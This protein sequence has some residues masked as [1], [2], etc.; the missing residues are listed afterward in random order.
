MGRSRTAPFPSVVRVVWCVAF[1]L[2]CLPAVAA[3]SSAARPI[4]HASIPVRFEP[5]RGQAPKSVR[6]VGRG[7][8]YRVAL[9]AKQV[10]ISVSPSIPKTVGR[11]ADTA[12]TMALVG[13]NDNASISA[14]GELPGKSSYFLQSDP[15]TWLTNLPTYSSV[16]SRNVYPR[17]DLV[18]RGDG[19]RL[20][21]DFRIGAGGDPARIA[22]RLDAKT[23]VSVDDGDLLVRRG[24]A[25]LRFLKPVSYQEKNGR[26]ETVAS[27][28]RVRH[29]AQG[30]TVEFE[31]G[32]YDRSRALIIDP[33]VL[34]GAVLAYSTQV[35]ALSEIGA[36]TVDGAGDVYLA[37]GESGGIDIVKLAPDGRTLLYD[38][39]I[40]SVYSSATGIAVD[41]QGQIYLTGYTYPGY[42]TTAGAYQ[43][44][45]GSGQHAFL[46]VV[47]ASGTGLIYSTYLEGSSTDYGDSV[48]IDPS[49]YVLVA[50]YTYSPDFPNTTSAQLSGA[51]AAFVTKFDIGQSGAA[52]LLWSTLL[53][54]TNYY[55]SQ[56][57]SV[58][59]DSAGNV[60]L[61]VDA[62]HLATS[63]G[64]YRYNAIDSSSSGVYVVELNSSG[65]Q[66]FVSYLGHGTAFDMA[67]D[68]AGNA[69]V[70]GTV[71]SGDYPATTGA[72]Q[73]SY[74]NAFVTKLNAGGGSLAYSTY[75]GGPSGQITPTSVTLPAGCT[76]NC[77]PL[78][79]GFVYG[80]DMPVV[81]AVQQALWGGTSY[82]NP[83]VFLTYLSADGSGAMFSTYFGGSN[84]DAYFR[85]NN[86]RIPQVGL[87]TAGNMYVAGY[88]YSSDFPFTTVFGSARSFVAKISP[89]AG[90]LVLPD[91]RSLSFGGQTM[92]VS[93]ASQTVNLRNFGT[94]AATIF[95]GPS[96]DNAGFTTTDNC[97]GTIP[98]GGS[99]AVQVTFTPKVAGYVSG[100]IT[101]GYNGNFATSFNVNGTGYDQPQ[102]SISPTTGA[103]F[104][105]V[106]VGTASTPQ[107]FTLT[108]IGS[109]P[110]S[111]N[112]VA[113]GDNTNF[114]LTATNCPGVL[115]V[116]ASCSFSIAFTPTRVGS[117]TSNFY[118]SSNA[119][120]TPSYS[121]YLT[122]TGTG[123]GTAAI[124]PSSTALNF[125]DQVVN[126]QS[127]AQ[128]VTFTNTGTIPVSL[129][130]GSTT[131][132]FSITSA[133][134]N[135]YTL[136]PGDSCT[137]YVAFTPATSGTRTGT[138]TMPNSTGTN[139]TVSLTGTGTAPTLGLTIS[140][141][142]LGF[143]DQ[144]VGTTSGANY[145]SVTN[146]GNATV[147]VS[148]V[149]DSG[150]DFHIT[151]NGCSTI[152]PLSSCQVNA[153]FTPSAA[154]ARTGTITFI[155]T[156]G[157]SPQVVSLSGNGMASTSS[158]I[159]SETSSTFDD[160]VVGSAGP[161]NALYLFNPGNT[162]VSVASVVSSAPQEFVVS[163][164][165]CNSIPAYGECQIN[166]QF[167]PQAAG[168]RTATLTVTHSAAGSPTVINLNGNGVAVAN[169][170]VATPLS[171]NFS[172]TV[173][174]TTSSGQYVYFY[175]P[176]NTGVTVSQV[177]ISG[178]FVI[179]S[180]ACGNPGPEGSCWVYV[181]FAPTAAGTRTGT[182][183]LFDS[184]PGSPHTVSL[185]GNGVNPVSTLIATPSS[186]GFDDQVVGTTSS[187]MYVTL[188]NPGNSDVTISNISATGDFSASGCSTLYAY[189]SCTL[190]LYFAPSAAGARTGTI[191]LTDTAAGSP[192]GIAVYGNGIAAT[193]TIATVPASLDFG[194]V[195]VSTSATSQTLYINNTGSQNVTISSVTA[196]SPFVV[197][198]CIT[199]IYAGSYCALSVTVNSSTTGTV[200]GTLTLTD[201]A[202]GSPHT[203]PLTA[204]IV[205]SLPATYITPNGLPLL[206]TVVGSTSTAN[207]VYFNNNSGSPVTVSA[208]N[209]TGDFA[210]SQNV[211]T[212]VL[213]DGSRC[214]VYVNFTPTATGLR[215]GTLVFTHN[216]PGGSTSINLA[217]YGDPVTT[218]VQISATALAFNDQVL[219]TSSNAQTVYLWNN[220]TTG[221]TMSAPT[222]TG[223]GF[224]L[225]YDSCGTGTVSPGSYCYYNV[226]F[227]P[228]AAGSAT[229]ALTIHSNDPGSPRVVTLAGNG[230]PASKILEP[231]A[232]GLSFADEA[233]GYSSAAQTVYF[234]NTGNTS[235]TF[236][237]VPA[238]TGDFAVQYSSCSTVSARSYC[239]VNITFTP[240][241]TGTR[242][243]TLTLTDDAAGSPHS[244][245]LTGNGIAATKTYSI[246]ATSLTFSDQPI[247]TTNY[248]AQVVTFYNTGT[249]PIAL[250]GTTLSNTTDFS[251]NYNSCT[252]Y[253]LSPNSYCYVYVEFQ[254]T[255][256]TPGTRT[257]S[258]TIANDAAAGPAVV[259]LSG[260]AVA[261]SNTAQLSATSLVFTDQAV[262]FTSSGNQY[263]YLYNTG[264]V[265]L[266][267][268]KLT[269]S[270]DFNLQYDYCSNYTL[271]PRDYCY[272]YVTFTPTAT[273]PR[274]GSISVPDSSAT[275]PHTVAL[276]GNGVA[277]SQRLS[278]TPA[279]LVFQPAPTGSGGPSSQITVQNVGN[280]PVQVTGTS[281]SGADFQKTY[282][283]CENRTLNVGDACY[284]NVQATPTVTGA[285]S[286]MLTITDNAAGSPHTVSLSG[287]GTDPNTS[288]Q[289]SQNALTFGAQPL[290]T[291][292]A[293]GVVY[294]VNQGSTVVTITA[295]T[296]SGPFVTTGC[297]SPGYNYNIYPP[298]S[299]AM[300]IQFAPP[301]NGTAGTYTGSVSIVDTA[302]GSP[303]VI[304]LSGTAVN[305]YPIASFNPASLSFGNQT[306]ATTSGAQSFSVYNT[307]SAP[308]T[309][310]SIAS[311][312][313]AEYAITY[314]SCPLSPSTLGV[315][316]GCT[317]SVAFTPQAAGTRTGAIQFTDDAGGSPQSVALT[318][319]G[320]AAAPIFNASP[321]V[322]DFG[323]VA[324]NTT[325]TPKTF[326]ITNT[327]GSNLV[328]S[329]A[330]GAVV[331][332]NY[333]ITGDT[334]SGTSLAPN[335]T[336]TVT[337]T[338]TPTG[339]QSI[340]GTLTFSD[341]AAGSPHVIG[342][343]GTGLSAPVLT[344]APGSL[345]FNPQQV[346]TSSPQ[347]TIVISNQGATV[348]FSTISVSAGPFS[349]TNNCGS[350]GNGQSC[351]VAVTYSPT[352]TGTQTATLSIA[353]DASGSPQTVS[354]SGTAVGQPAVTLS[355]TSLTF[356]NQ[357]VGTTSAAQSIT[358]T[359]TGAGPLSISSIAASNEFTQT[360]NCGNSLI[361]NGSCT[362]NVTFTPAG[363]N[364]RT[365]TITISDNAQNS[366]QTISLSGTGLG[367]VAT[368]APSSLT[369]ASQAVGTTSAAQSFTLTNTGNADLLITSIASN[370]SQ[371]GESNN[372]ASTMTA[373]SSCTISV[374]YSPTV[375]GAVSGAIIINTSNDGSPSVS[376]TGS[377]TGPVSSVS[378]TSLNFGSVSLNT[379]SATQT[380]TLSSTGTTDLT[381][382]TIAISGDY[383]QTNNCPASLATGSNCTIN[384]TFTP[385][386]AGART[387]TLTIPDNGA[388]GGHSVALAG[389]GL[390]PL[391][392]LNPSSLNFS[393]IAIGATASAQSITVANNGTVSITGLTVSVTAG[394]FAQSNNCPASLAVGGTCTINVTFTPTQ[395]G[396]RSAMLSVASNAATQSAS[397]SG[398]GTGPLVQLNPTSL[399]FG[400]QII[401]TASSPQTVTLTNVGNASLNIA[402]ITGSGDF[403]DQHNCPAALGPNSS[404]TISVTFTPT[405]AGTRTG[406]VTVDDDAQGSPQSFALT[407]TGVLPQADMSVTGNASP[408]SLQPNGSTT[409]TF[410]VANAGPSTA[411]TVTFNA[412]L[413]TNAQVTSASASSG[414][415]TIAS[416]ISCALADMPANGSATVIIAANATA[417]GTLSTTAT[418][419]AAQSDNA[420]SNNSATVSAVVGEADLLVNASAGATSPSYVVTVTNNGPTSASQV[421]LTCAYDRYGYSSSNSTQGSC[422][423]NG[424]AM[425]CALG[426]LAA[427]ASASVTQL[428]Q[429]P[430]TGWANISCH[431]G[432]NEFD[433]NPVNNAAQISPEGATNTNVGSNVSVVLYDRV[434]GAQ[435]R[436]VFPSVS[437][438]GV[439]T[440]TSAAGANPP[441]GFRNGAQAWTYDVSTTASTIGSPVVTFAV[442]TTM[443]HHPAKVRLFHM[444][445]GAWVDRTAT[446]DAGAVAA[447]TNSLSP[448][449]LFEPIDQVPIANAGS[450]RVA[451]GTSRL[452]TAVT[453]DGTASSDVDG[454]SLS[455]RWTGPFP[456]GNGV[457]TGAHPT[458]TLPFGASKVSL[459]VNDGEVDSAATTVQFNV[460]DFGVSPASTSV[461]V[462]RGS[463]VT[464]PVQ[465]PAVGG[466]FDQNVTLGCANLP[467]GMRC[468]FSPATVKPGATGA[469]STLTI[470]TTTSVAMS[471]RPSPWG[472]AAMMF[473]IVG[474]FGWPD[475]RRRRAVFVAL[476]LVALVILVQVGCGGGATVNTTTNQP[477]TP[478]SSTVTISV[479]GT[480][481]GLSHGS[482]VTVTVH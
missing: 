129:G 233:V 348:T 437:K 138:L 445:N 156:A 211:C 370:S 24:D 66:Q 214:Y 293:A 346:N 268:G 130:T 351:S 338:F 260:N 111:I 12:V 481:A 65:A 199:T 35:G 36:M 332:T 262:G 279:N 107:T 381:V 416:S 463:S 426:S 239:Y 145:I 376:L 321:T 238:I 265:P 305:P 113:L 209:T 288:F 399:N 144:T 472:L 147:T 380:I 460:T 82:Y 79:G 2:L 187:P 369:F 146:N 39:T 333:A 447:I 286:G 49:G 371:F 302:T 307:G 468:T 439:T 282:S 474:V 349:Q 103:A 9:E 41:G 326:T 357:N 30:S 17:T 14:S 236:S 112:Y 345:I 270:G 281:I 37:S 335:A 244:V 208:V 194:S 429:P 316:S 383:A 467:A 1:S 221:V 337:V 417:I 312:N 241:A 440:V 7:A 476:L 54:T 73:T 183:T 123:V 120:V 359:N 344:I 203:I 304:A 3:D 255:G 148:R 278:I 217:G 415:C 164:N 23:E 377:G 443:F 215:T 313:S 230:I 95:S 158:V 471:R 298:S 135:S 178:D 77:T 42:V 186:V 165:G 306:V 38:A 106:A 142:T 362:I 131:G 454:D 40:G 296:V 207:Y 245:T 153:V 243:G 315:G 226:A 393:S 100:T 33:V 469:A 412:T 4:N 343:A 94:T 396:A 364:T 122:G 109:Q 441:A 175:N 256:G 334:C 102:L 254:P 5:N 407:G 15:R 252:T 201:T 457:V 438:S 136:A 223:A 119:N 444:E 219:N 446:Q 72:Y 45:A 389:V 433:P 301:A 204:N 185:S 294:L 402:A 403:A 139:Q 421:L 309:I 353:D 200:N 27:A 74:P 366:P 84:D 418:V 20:E 166:V 317:L 329:P 432:A 274:T 76:T 53:S 466:A 314:N 253:S 11:P 56:A 48:T 319:N 480:S 394:D 218:A 51:Y 461:E 382:G 330:A 167:Q 331:T 341:N 108:S 192:H 205:S 83:D 197:S 295:A 280:A 29:D 179:G 161:T 452:G 155:D 406:S 352:A 427:G 400:N 354:L 285:L 43:P 378:P 240:T 291:T 32:A 276:S 216:G 44:V 386:A 18:F 134:C 395:A 210:V 283:S 141:A 398:A 324:L 196:T 171:V 375:G 284:V 231:S 267:V 289:L 172:D 479:T 99:C 477:T 8:G 93:T 70:V 290:G 277:A 365:G 367:A 213:N 363:A 423:F 189:S 404:C 455:Y 408:A 384:V 409:Y 424:T 50:G 368:V 97:G 47:N 59:T 206:R 63:A 379:A 22:W 300:S 212:S 470:S 414:T 361:V 325:S 303:H 224:V 60:Y 34:P 263:V 115:P 459:V 89:T 173:V 88:T 442:P 355:S 448:F 80:S 257:G 92:T 31:I 464:V 75:L 151:Y 465:V 453:L 387:G 86:Y 159:A 168:A 473:G 425:S 190:Y 258:F 358:M 478:A 118:I 160:T 114:S 13:A 87:D 16:L 411:T 125:A 391:I 181:Q 318:G 340:N 26:R 237:G 287:M 222:I 104:G 458:V 98:A 149:Y 157:N 242:T 127:Y 413:P 67:V 124:T 250:S 91:Q 336:C 228:T 264:N 372:C 420:T 350:L 152:Q 64:A 68:G 311:S 419:S 410:T 436:V 71:S 482:N 310:S 169:S 150:G 61:A 462:A 170:L 339:A 193:S 347:Q 385:V 176:G 247:G 184:A 450:D 456:E 69:Y 132:D 388:S 322:Y 273:G 143:A 81:Q 323:G 308:M 177:S 266:S 360:N 180:N 28:Y 162:P 475:K 191:T 121:S 188:Y 19:S 275:T 78:V 116:G 174:G 229:G 52:S 10:T 401:N 430:S 405:A 390:G 292:S 198:G 154:G 57:V 374:T 428:V 235:V 46:T 327:G 356:A 195:A 105:A 110:A 434:S 225:Q 6:Y 342:L 259:T 58:K 227:Q 234:Y 202:S 249:A 55:Y 220:G 392:S 246:S 397:L 128:H 248:N 25:Q 101:V 373:T 232:T 320:I 96:S 422:S 133:G 328:F 297:V 451:A 90:S 272:F 271:S 269:A 117:F 126:I 182:L 85:S 163:Y 431:A 137:V 261:A 435:A 251:I 62:D 21:Y 299:C 449:A 140:P